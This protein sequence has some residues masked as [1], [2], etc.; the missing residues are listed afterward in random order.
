M[1]RKAWFKS[2]KKGQNTEGPI[3]TKKSDSLFD[4]RFLGNI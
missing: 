2:Y 4:R 1:M 3:S